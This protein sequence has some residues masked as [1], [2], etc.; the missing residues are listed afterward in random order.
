MYIDR[1]FKTTVEYYVAHISDSIKNNKS[2]LQF[3]LGIESQKIFLY[4]SGS[5]FISKLDL[6]EKATKQNFKTNLILKLEHL[7]D[8]PEEIFYL[9]D[10]E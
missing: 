10:K 4:Y 2:E 9:F 3:G 5:Y 1:I 7:E 6:E 8:F